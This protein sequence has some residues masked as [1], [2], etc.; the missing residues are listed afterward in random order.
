VDEGG[1][2]GGRAGLQM[3]PPMTGPCNRSSVVV[4]HGA[5][6]VDKSLQRSIKDTWTHIYWSSTGQPPPTVREGLH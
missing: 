1:W 2:L 3:T 6:I 4:K 5:V